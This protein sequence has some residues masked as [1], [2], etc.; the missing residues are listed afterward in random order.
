[1][2]LREILQLEQSRRNIDQIIKIVKNNPEL[3]ESL[4]SIFIENK[5]PESRRAAW[6]IDI[7]NEDFIFLEAS[8][9][10]ILIHL[11]PTF[12]HD[13]FK[14]HSL[15]ILERN[16]IPQ[17]CIGELMSICFDWLEASDSPVAVK[18]YCLKILSGIAEK[19]P[20]ICRELMDIIE[21]QMIDSTPGFKS[22]GTK[23]IRKLQK[24]S[25]F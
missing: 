6:A 10:E 2:N 3:F 16:L 7:L 23:I 9:L 25:A 14:R 20:A 5:N 24:R 22:I 11:L 15:R 18:M 1:M 17:E 12:K 21:I 4:W 13:G 19:E 8:H